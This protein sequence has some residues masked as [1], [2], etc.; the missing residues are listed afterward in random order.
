MASQPPAAHISGGSGQI[1]LWWDLSWNCSTA[2]QKH[3]FLHL[4]I[5]FPPLLRS[6]LIVPVRLCCQSFKKSL[7]H[8]SCPTSMCWTVPRIR[9]FS[10]PKVGNTQIVLWN[11]CATTVLSN[12]MSF[13]CDLLCKWPWKQNISTSNTFLEIHCQVSQLPSSLEWER[14][15]VEGE[16]REKFTF[17]SVQSRAVHTEECFDKYFCVARTGFIRA[18]YCNANGLCGWAAAGWRQSLVCVS[19][20]LCMAS[21]MVTA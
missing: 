20:S 3:K 6:F 4:K 11:C 21:W 13:S 19:V 15:F 12:G 5:P 10:W 17:C 8:T 18:P 16:E 1:P 2:V 7:P 14:D 9:N